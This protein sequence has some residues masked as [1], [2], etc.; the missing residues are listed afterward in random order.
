[1][2]IL[3]RVRGWPGYVALVAVLSVPFYLLGTGGASLPFVAAL[4]LSAV[5]VVIPTLAAVAL[6]ESWAGV[7]RLLARLGQ[8][9]GLLWSIIAVAIMPLVFWL[10]AVVMAT[11]GAHLPAVQWLPATGMAAAM[12]IFAVGAVFEEWGWQGYAYPRMRFAPLW[13]ALLVGVI[14]AL[15]HVVPFAEMGHSGAWIFWHCLVT[16]ALR[17]IM[18]WLVESARQNLVIAVLFHMMINAPFGV[19][20]NFAVFY[21]PMIAAILLWLLVVALV[22]LHGAGLGR[23]A[24]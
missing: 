22:V 18:V 23:E 21:D 11:T 19:I 13:S 24:G 17:I 2:E 5:M 4:P 3:S 6:T 15:W 10:A 12:V 14:W 16:V 1:M 9:P 7:R 8:W 20:G